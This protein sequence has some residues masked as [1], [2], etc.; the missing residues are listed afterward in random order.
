MK[1]EISKNLIFFTT[2]KEIWENLQQ[3]YSKKKDAALIYELKKLISSTQQG[4]MSVTEYYN[5]MNGFWLEIDHNWDM[6]LECNHDIQV[7][8]ELLENDRV[9]E[10]LAGFEFWVRSN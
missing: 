7:V 6:K 10:F 8:Q 3:T 5:Q 1:P 4:G 2:A 9:F